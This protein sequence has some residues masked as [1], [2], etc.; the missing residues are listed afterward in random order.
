MTRNFV[1]E[2]SFF[3]DRQSVGDSSKVVALE[4][5]NVRKAT[6]RFGTMPKG[7]RIDAFLDSLNNQHHQNV[8][9]EESSSGIGSG[10]SPAENADSISGSGVDNES[11]QTFNEGLE[12]KS[13][14]LNHLNRFNEEFLS[15]L[16]QRLRSSEVLL[17]SFI[18]VR[19]F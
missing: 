8:T 9:D 14:D 13:S 2:F 6:S 10:G 7:A 18:L 17:H 1:F 11:A 15:Q 3:E 19:Q 12:G 16:K 5:K 4:E